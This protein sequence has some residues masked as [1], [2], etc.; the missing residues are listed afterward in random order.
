M[1]LRRLRA[2]EG[3]AYRA[4]RLR[5]LEAEP[6]AY[7]QTLA[8]ALADPD[9]LWD[10]LAASVAGDDPRALFV[11]DR[12]DGALA[13]TLYVAISEAP[14]HFGT[15]GAMWVDEDLRAHG[16]ADALMESALA[17]ATGWGAAG[18][19]LWVASG[20]ERALRLYTRHGFQPTGNIERWEAD[21]TPREAQELFCA[22]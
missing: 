1:E 5:A 4:V 18:M 19:S 9:T 7:G 6:Q 17:W 12:G 11:V 13:G 16:W 10:D 8:E 2:D 20:N 15:L 14:P 3:H 21:G 22:L